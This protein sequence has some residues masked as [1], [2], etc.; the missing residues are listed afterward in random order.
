MRT[1]AFIFSLLCFL[2]YIKNNR[3]RW[4][5]REQEPAEDSQPQQKRDYHAGQLETLEAMLRRAVE[6]E[7]R[8]AGTL[9][10]SEYLNRYGVVVN[11]KNLKRQRDS[12]YT[13]QRKRLAIESQLHRA[14]EAEQKAKNHGG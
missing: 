3:S 4:R 12:L 1:A 14:R 11:E 5:G 8:A 7:E 13:A 9:E 10:R 2:L 6:E